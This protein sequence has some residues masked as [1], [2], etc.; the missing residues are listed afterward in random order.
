MTDLDHNWDGHLKQELDD[1]L[2][3]KIE[4]NDQLK[5]NIRQKAAA[6]HAK[7]RF[8]VPK[9]W[10]IGAAALTAAVIMIAGY[11]MLQQEADPIST[12]HS[13]IES[14]PPSPSDSIDI[15]LSSLITTTLNSVEEAKASF[16]EEL[17]LPTFVPEGFTLL[18]MA[19]TGIEGEAARDIIFTYVSDDKTLSFVASRNT[20]SFQKEMFSPIKIEDTDGYVLEQPELIELFWIVDGIQYSITGSLSADEALR[21]AES[22]E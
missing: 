8:R 10:T 11:S 17:L 6:E 14:L 3:S 5:M 13:I 20:A 7:R 22:L 15:G 16:G 12:E 4:W 9:S 19:A 1:M 18:E 2:F 21:M